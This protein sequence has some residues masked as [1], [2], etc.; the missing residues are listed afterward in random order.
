MPPSTE[1]KHQA[2]LNRL[3]RIEPKVVEFIKLHGSLIL[4]GTS[5]SLSKGLLFHQ[6]D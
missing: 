3:G 5:S 2:Y 4:E 6:T 1:A